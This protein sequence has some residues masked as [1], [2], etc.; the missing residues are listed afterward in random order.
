MNYRYLC[1]RNKFANKKREAPWYRVTYRINFE[2]RTVLF[3]VV[4]PA[5]PAAGKLTPASF[6]ISGRRWFAPLPQSATSVLVLASPSYAV[7]AHSSAITERSR[8]AH[9][10]H[11]VGPTF[12]CGLRAPAARVSPCSDAPLAAEA[13]L[14]STVSHSHLLPFIK[15]LKS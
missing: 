5:A 7:P 10:S 6:W 4:E 1:G 13:S 11:H 8:S 15:T 9:R 2:C 3:S 12:P 14:A